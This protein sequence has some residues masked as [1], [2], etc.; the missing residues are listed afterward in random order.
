MSD[1]SRPLDFRTLF[2]LELPYVSRCLQRMG[3]AP[4]DVE[5]VCSELFFAVHGALAD[6]D[7]TRPLRPWL[8]GFCFRFASDYRR[9]GRVRARTFA[10]TAAERDLADEDLDGADVALERKRDRQ[11]VRDALDTIDLDR[12]SVLVAHE[13]EG[14]SIPE[15]ARTL[16]IPLGT[17]Y[18]RLRLA[19]RD[20]AAALG[21]PPEEDERSTDVRSTHPTG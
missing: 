20:L 18:T 6:Y 5:D 7:T 12:R 8:F 9:R 15:V 14:I 13:L 17:A 4:A 21:L 10:A 16:E 2:H 19:R 1:A 11:R 3:V